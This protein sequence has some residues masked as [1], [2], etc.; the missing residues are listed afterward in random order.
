MTGVEDYLGIPKAGAVNQRVALKDIVEQLSLSGSEK[1]H[2]ESDTYSVHLIGVLDAD[3]IHVMP[4]RDEVYLYETIYVIKAILKSTNHFSFVVETIHAAFPNPLIIIFEKDEKWVISLASKR[5][6][7][8]NH[9]KSVIESVISTDWFELDDQHI[10]MLE[11]LKLYGISAVN[12]KEFYERVLSKTFL[13]KLIKFIGYYPQ[14]S[15]MG[16]DVVQIIGQLEQETVQLHINED[17][18]RCSS[19][20]SEKMD[21]HIKITKNKEKIVKIINNLLEGMH[22]D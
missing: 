19:M 13:E 5:I 21:F 20:M 16:V 9:D 22:S 17:L 6:N 14:K 1:K 7:K 11:T 8:N 2:F 18:Y 12:Q 15:P 10:K 4:Y 3:T